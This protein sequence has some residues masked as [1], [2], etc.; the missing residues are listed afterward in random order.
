MPKKAKIAVSPP[1]ETE[2]LSRVR[3]VRHPVDLSHPLRVTK[4]PRITGDGS[5]PQISIPKPERHPY[6]EFS[7]AVEGRWI[8]FIGMEKVER[9]PG[10]LMLLGPGTPHYATHLAYPIRV[11]GIY[12]LP[13]LLFELSPSDGARI[14]NRFTA[15]RSISQRV[16]RP[17]KALGRKLAE[18]FES[19]A[20]EFDRPKLGSDTRLRSLLMDVLI[21]LLR[22]E[23][24]AGHAVPFGSASSKWVQIEKVLHF[25]YEHYTEPLYIEQIAREAG[26]STDDL[27]R[28]FRDAFGMSCIQ[29]LRAY[30]ISHA[31]SLLSLP[32]ARVTEIAPAV[33]FE[34]LS[35]FNASFR[36]FQGISPREYVRSHK[37]IK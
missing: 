20:D 5:L 4:S 14:L 23:E 12:F 1:S 17:P 10:D 31:A 36:R 2:W 8:Q 26:L 15:G 21:Q 6:C 3:E 24:S 25:I 13:L 9:S 28:L 29:Y 30:R 34:T 11:I 27:Y 19:I 16:V 37:T 22:W 33:G 35:H 7:F 32:G 18:Q